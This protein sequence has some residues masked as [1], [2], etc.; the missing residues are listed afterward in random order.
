MTMKRHLSKH[1]WLEF[2]QILNSTESAES[3][4]G[5]KSSSSVQTQSCEVSF[6]GLPVNYQQHKETREEIINTAKNF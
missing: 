6:Q 1:E 4:E 2:I 5:F 3:G